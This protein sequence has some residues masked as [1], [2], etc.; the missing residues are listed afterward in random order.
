MLVAR[1]RIDVGRIAVAVKADLEKTWR[2]IVG[3][4]EVLV[5]LLQCCRFYAMLVARMLTVNGGSDEESSAGSKLLGK[6]SKPHDYRSMMNDLVILRMEL[7]AQG[8]WKN[9]SLSSSCLEVDFWRA[10]GDAARIGWAMR[11][12]IQKKTFG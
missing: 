3:E 4:V 6:F 8:T 10:R 2:S 5:R 9:C 1:E 11:F 12:A 7:T